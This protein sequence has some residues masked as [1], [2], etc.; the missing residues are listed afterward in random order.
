M[1]TLKE[2][3]KRGVHKSLVNEAFKGIE[4]NTR[5]T[6]GKIRYNGAVVTGTADELKRFQDLT[7]IRASV[8]GAT[9][10]KY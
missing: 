7:F 6:E 1:R 5:S 4:G 9:I 2:L 8:L 10:D 3:K